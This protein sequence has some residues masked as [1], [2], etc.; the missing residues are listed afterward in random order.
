VQLE[1]TYPYRFTKWDWIELSLVTIPANPDCTIQTV[2]SIVDRE[3]AALG[4]TLTRGVKLIQR[5]QPAAQKGAGV[6]L[7]LPA[8]VSADSEIKQ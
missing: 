5:V 8:G 6:K 7:V 1:G 3:R 4:H 2:K